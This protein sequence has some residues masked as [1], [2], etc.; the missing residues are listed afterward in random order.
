MDCFLACRKTVSHLKDQQ[1]QVATEY[2]TLTLNSLHLPSFQI[3]H[4]CK[5]T[6]TNVLVKEFQSF[7]HQYVRNR[8]NR[9]IDHRPLK[10]IDFVRAGRFL[11]STLAENRGHIPSKS[12]VL[13]II[14][15]AGSLY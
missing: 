4:S 15:P 9:T 6:Y 7:A 12:I 3:M 13:S 1:F 11:K 10:S 5:V 14:R 8:E 2:I